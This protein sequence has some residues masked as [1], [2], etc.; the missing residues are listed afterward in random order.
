MGVMGYTTTLAILAHT[1]HAHVDR[2]MRTKDVAYH[3]MI[4]D[5]HRVMKECLCTSKEELTR[6]VAAHTW[7]ETVD[8]V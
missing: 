5:L 3:I 1:L 6:E 4:N 8:Y 7:D 2:C